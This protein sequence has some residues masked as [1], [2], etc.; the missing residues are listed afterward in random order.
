MGY[1]LY[2]WH[3]L[4]CVVKSV[5]IFVIKCRNKVHL[6]SVEQKSRRQ[7]NTIIIHY[8]STVDAIVTN[9]PAQHTCDGVQYLGCT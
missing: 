6:R 5:I 7:T 4:F 1:N 9:V 8:M 2:I 3:C